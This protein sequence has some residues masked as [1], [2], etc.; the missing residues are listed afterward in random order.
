MALINKFAYWEKAYHRITS[1][2]YHIDKQQLRIRTDVYPDKEKRKDYPKDKVITEER[3]ITEQ[4]LI[5][6]SREKATKKINITNIKKFV[7][8]E[9]KDKEL[10]ARTKEQLLQEETE[11]AIL[12]K[13]YELGR[14]KM[15][16][17]KENID[18]KGIIFVAYNCLKLLA[19]FEEAKDI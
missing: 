2:E 13:M 4:I 9:E 11:K 10:N 6:N 5:D 12:T 17:F 1:I 16:T 8:R 15:Q 14:A 7:N 19:E 3:L 18:K